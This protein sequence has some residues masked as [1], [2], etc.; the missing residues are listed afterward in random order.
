[1]KFVELATFDSRL[2]AETIGHALDQYDIPFLVQSAGVGMFGMGM[3]GKSPVPVKLC[4]PDNRLDE[5]KELLSC[6]AGPL[7]EGEESPGDG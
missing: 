4:V 2:E 6:V 3:M 7:E 5:V 1:M